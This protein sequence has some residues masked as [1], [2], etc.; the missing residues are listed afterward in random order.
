MEQTLFSMAIPEQPRRAIVIVQTPKK[1]TRQGM[2]QTMGSERDEEKFKGGWRIFN[3]LITNK[4]FDVNILVG[5]NAAEESV[6]DAN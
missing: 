1:S 6:E 5:Q 2:I 3:N 4:R